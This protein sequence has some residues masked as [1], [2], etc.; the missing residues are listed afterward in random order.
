MANSL[1]TL[2]LG[3]GNMEQATLACQPGAGA[4]LGMAGW[5]WVSSHSGIDSLNF[6]DMG[7]RLPV[8]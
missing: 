5:K 1:A 7:Y 8:P 6:R 3:P 4:E 2:L